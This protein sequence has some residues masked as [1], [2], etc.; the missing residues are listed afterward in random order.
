MNLSEAQESV[1]R[2]RQTLAEIVKGDQEQEVRGVALPVIDAVIEAARAHVKQDDPVLNAITGLISPETIA[3]G[4]PIRA[5]DALVLVDQLLVALNRADLRD[6][7][8]FV[9]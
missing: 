6:R 2:L 3:E 8:P 7:G 4:E 9:G 5:I 1:L